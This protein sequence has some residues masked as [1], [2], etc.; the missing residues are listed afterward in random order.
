MHK[1]VQRSLA[2][3]AL[4][5]I[6]VTAQAAPLDGGLHLVLN[7]GITGGGD[8][9]ATA[10]YSNG[11]SESIKAGGLLQLG[12]GLL[13]QATSIPMATQITANYHV[14]DITASNGNAKFDRIPIE[15]TFFYTGIDKWRF[16]AGARFVQSAKYTS[17][18]DNGNDESMDFKDTTGALIEVGYG[19]TPHMWLNLRFVSER[20]RPKTD[21]F[22]GVTVNASN[23]RSYDGSHIGL[24]F[25]Y[26]F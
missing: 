11:T 13:W 5:S 18:V 16:G 3:A 23:L 21:T 15:L 9:I 8:T 25:L 10:H 19:F 4:S 24:N 7:A 17:H 2:I 14:D 22:N 26:A 1:F 6:A 12:G 20:Y